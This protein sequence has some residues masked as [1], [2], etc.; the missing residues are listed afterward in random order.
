MAV[1]KDSRSVVLIFTVVEDVIINKV[2][3][4]ISAPCLRADAPF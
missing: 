1:R 4:E 2:V 3:Y